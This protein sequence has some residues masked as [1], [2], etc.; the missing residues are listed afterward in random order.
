MI[1]HVHFPYHS[2]LLSN[3]ESHRKYKEERKVQVH[4]TRNEATI[5]VPLRFN[6]YNEHPLASKIVIALLSV[7]PPR[8]AAN[9]FI[10]N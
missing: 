7:S 9:I 10:K 2:V 4:N 8:A 1:F 3:S 6:F 5:I